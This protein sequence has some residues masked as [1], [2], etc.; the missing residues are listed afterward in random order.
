MR[1]RKIFLLTSICTATL[2]TVNLY[3]TP[4]TTNIQQLSSQQQDR[5]RSM[6]KSNLDS[7]FPYQ[8]QITIGKI[9]QDNKGTVVASNILIMSN[10]S[11]NP[12]LTINKLIF[13]GL[14]ANQAINNN[15]TIKVE[16]LSIANLAA[17]VANSNLVSSEVDPKQLADNQGLF[18]IAMN[19]LGQTIY[20]LEINYN[21]NNS[22]IDYSLDSTINNKPLLKAAAQLT[23]IDLSNTNVNTDFL[24]TLLNE[25]MSAKI[26]TLEFDANFSEVLRDITNK[27]LGKDYKQ[28][29][30]LNIKAQL[31]KNPD[32]LMLNVD[33]KLGSQ[34]YAK[35]NIII[36]GINL[37][38]STIN[39][40]VAGSSNALD[41]AY[42]QSSTSSSRIELNFA[43]DFFPKGSPI[44]QVFSA[45]DKNNISFTIVSQHQFEG[46]SYNTN[47]Y[48]KADG[49]ASLS[50][51]ANAV[52]NGKLNL[53]PYLGINAQNQTNLYDCTNQLC[54]S[55]VDVKFANYGLLEK[56]AR[57]TNNDPNTTPQQILGSYGALLQL[58][59]VQQQDKFLQQTLSA[60][61]IFLQN[62]K[63]I[64]IHAKANK[65]VN[66]N[67]L[68]N[69]LVAD[70]KTLKKYKP[71]NS[72]GNVDLRNNP[73]VK[74]IN[75]IQNIFKISF[76]VNK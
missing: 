29:P 19:S 40:I 61:A 52:V 48:L 45:L 72:N 66:E 28:T 57:Q 43:R 1:L 36:N 5:I 4:T 11:E 18:S 21:Y 27:Y 64:A 13:K 30:I 24:A 67:A 75:N 58:F 8:T 44:I 70:A 15:F 65:P 33:G 76:D 9:D 51:N 50:A 39:D 63:N 49:L 32:Q 56:V 62:P 2:A 69:M 38:S 55:N 71:V 41:N 23:D 10:D 59:A 53:L 31:G 17:A 54:L 3:A 34:N 25:S 12:N 68:L 74:L 7:L 47:F 42:I 14:H 46:T 16:G 37:A 73:N 26:K 35:Y 60:F 20:N 22:T 6:L